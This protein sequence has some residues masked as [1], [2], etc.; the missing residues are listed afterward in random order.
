M[1]DESVGKTVNVLVSADVPFLLTILTKVVR[2]ALTLDEVVETLVNA[3]MV[4]NL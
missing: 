4:L 1:D 3:L 2:N